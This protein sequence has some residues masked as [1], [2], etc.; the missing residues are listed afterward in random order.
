MHF[1]RRGNAGN[2]KRASVHKVTHPGSR[3]AVGLVARVSSRREI[4]S[5]SSRYRVDRARNDR[6]LKRQLTAET[7]IVNHHI[8][9]VSA[10]KIQNILRE[11]GF[12]VARRSKVQFRAR[13][14]VI[15]DLQHREPLIVARSFLSWQ[16]GHLTCRQVASGH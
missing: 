6:V 10:V 2:R 14:N 11:C 13:R 7:D 5:A 12:A 9:L 3:S 4:N 16:Y 8:A 1:I 15:D